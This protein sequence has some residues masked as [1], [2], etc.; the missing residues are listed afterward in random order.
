MQGTPFSSHW[1]ATGLVVSE[2]EEATMTSTRSRL[3][4]WAAT[5]EARFGLD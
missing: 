3:I 2:V 1:S 5:S 4:S